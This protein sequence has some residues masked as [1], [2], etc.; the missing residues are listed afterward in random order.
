M[1][2]KSK[3]T[4]SQCDYFAKAYKSMKHGLHALNVKTKSQI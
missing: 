4:G 3:I 2:K 1:K